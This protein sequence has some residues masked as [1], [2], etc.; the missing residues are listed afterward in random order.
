MEG[1][2]TKVCAGSNFFALIIL[3]LN[4]REFV[5]PNSGLKK[6]LVVRLPL[7]VHSF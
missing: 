2:F 6:R 4:P 3:N 7:N 5:I 1:A